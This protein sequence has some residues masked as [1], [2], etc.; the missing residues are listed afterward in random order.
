MNEEKKGLKES[1]ELLKAIELIG[2]SG[3]EI[4][5]DGLGVDD[6]SKAVDLLK[7]INVIIEGVKGVGEIGAEIKDLDQEELIQLG[8]ALFGSYKKIAEAAK[9]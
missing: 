9:A 3:L 8:L 2:V 6:I 4:A 5:K 7:Q 1:L